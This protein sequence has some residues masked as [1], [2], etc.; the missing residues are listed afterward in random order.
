MHSVYLDTNIISYLHRPEECA[1]QSWHKDLPLALDFI[2]QATKTEFVYSPAHLMD[3]RRGYKKDRAKALEKLRFISQI[4]RN[5]RLTKYY[6]SYDVLIKEADPEVFFLID[7]EYNAEF[8]APGKKKLDYLSLIRMTPAYERLK[9]K[10]VDIERVKRALAAVPIKLKR[11][12]RD[13][14]VYN[15]MCDFAVFIGEMIESDF[16]IYE[17]FRRQ[18]MKETG[19][20][21]MIAGKDDPLSIIQT[22]LNATLFGQR[23]KQGMYELMAEDPF[24]RE[25]IIFG[26]FMNLDFLGFKKDKISD[27]HGYMS[28]ATDATHCFYASHCAML[29]TNDDRTAKKAAAVY[30][31]LNVKTDVKTM[32]EF[33]DWIKTEGT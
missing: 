22:H 8:H 4:S 6:G 23:M 30:K 7:S 33:L 14:T 10:R 21:G 28:I 20:A 9:Q 12:R 15:L 13:P 17:T 5:R 18:A 2:D 24:D 31:Y 11:T 29:I 1:I 3:V 16:P 27:G 25:G 19:L 32:P 26:L